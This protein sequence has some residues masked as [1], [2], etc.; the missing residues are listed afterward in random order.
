MV[1]HECGVIYID[2]PFSGVKSFEEF[3]TKDEDYVLDKYN[4][5]GYINSNIHEISFNE[6]IS[7]FENVFK[8]KNS[9]KSD[10]VDVINKY[11]PDF[12]HIET[13]KSL[14]QKM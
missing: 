4:S 3:Y 1:S 6:V 7:D 5:L 9:Q 8:D 14:D 2:V 11:V 12:S 10:L 13:G